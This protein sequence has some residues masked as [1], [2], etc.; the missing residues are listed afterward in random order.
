M[1]RFFVAILGLALA[2]LGW[3]FPRAGAGARLRIPAAILLDLLLPALGFAIVCAASARPLFA[4]ATILALGGGYAYADRAKRAVLAEPVVFTD[5]FQALDIFRHPQLALP[6]PHVGRVLAGVTAALAFFAGLF[7]WEAP[8]WRESLWPLLILL[9]LTAIGVWLASSASSA[10]LGRAL[11]RLK[12]LGDPVR[13]AARFGPLATLLIHG[14]IA[15]AER[16]QRRIA[17]PPMPTPARTRSPTAGPIVLVQCESFFDARRLHPGIPADLL[18]N[19]DRLRTTGMQWGGLHVPSWGANTVRTEFEV[20]TGLTQSQIGMDWFDPY[21]RFADAPVDSLAWRLKKEGYR[22]ICLHPFDRSFY[23]RDRVMANLGFDVF[24]G[25]EAF[26]DARV[27]NG[28]IADGEVAR[29]AATILAEKNPRTFLFLITM[30]NHGPWRE[31][32]ETRTVELAADMRMPS[33]EYRS[34]MCYLEGLKSADAMLE[35][36]ASA[37]SE[38]GDNGLLGFYGDHLP[39]FPETFARLGLREPGSDYLLWRTRNAMGLRKD[40][41]ARELGATLVMNLRQPSAAAAKF[42]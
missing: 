3:Y 7:L 36:L 8:A 31:G 10:S 15:R 19:F 6:F 1:S 27:R 5:V 11:R 28:Y 38:R 41:H 32:L 22:T 25:E 39:G 12:P 42:A 14:L 30:E 13:D 23:R 16:A 26:A 4:G 33:A 17:P 21:H 2:L 35:T 29:L 40:V 24:L 34:F 37:L 18:P 20:L 9:G